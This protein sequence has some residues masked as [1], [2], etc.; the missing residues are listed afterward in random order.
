[1]GETLSC[2]VVGM[3]G[4]WPGLPY[5]LHGSSPGFVHGYG[6]NAVLF[7]GRGLG[8]IWLAESRK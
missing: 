7:I 1:M 6:L 3:L 8:D 2:M 5:V 4:A